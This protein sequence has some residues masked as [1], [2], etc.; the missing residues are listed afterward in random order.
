M[1]AVHREF[2]RAI[3][4]HFSKLESTAFLHTSQNW[5]GLL[6][7]ESHAPFSSRYTRCP[8][9]SRVAKRAHTNLRGRKK[10]K[11]PFSRRFTV[12]SRRPQ[13]GTQ[14]GPTLCGSLSDLC[15]SA[16]KF[17]L[18]LRS[19][20]RG[21]GLLKTGSHFFTPPKS[22][23]SAASITGLPGRADLDFRI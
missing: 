4:P 7:R 9:S 17:S 3:P 8:A 5:R 19:S 23:S 2:V 6:R 12:E 13:R 1:D 16:V 11:F 14:R 21:D 22:H 18:H 20:S 10:N 15:D